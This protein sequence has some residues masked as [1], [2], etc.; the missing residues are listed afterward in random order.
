[1]W[2]FIE[3]ACDGRQLVWNDHSRDPQESVTELGLETD[4]RNRLSERMRIDL[5]GR[6][7]LGA[8]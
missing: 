3:I 6:V 5:S 2:W 4:L 1:M 8:R 7:D